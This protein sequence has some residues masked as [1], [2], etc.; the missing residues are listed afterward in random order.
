MRFWWLIP[1]IKIKYSNS[2]IYLEEI[3]LMTFASLLVSIVR[4][5]FWTLIR[6]ENEF[7]NNFEQYRDI[8]HIPPIKDDEE[9]DLHK[10]YTNNYNI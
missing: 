8:L 3:E 7:H 2:T 9:E 4:R 6:V 1:A 10:W 5:T